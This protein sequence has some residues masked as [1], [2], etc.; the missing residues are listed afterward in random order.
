MAD[1]GTM[2]L[3]LALALAVYAGVG[4]VA[5][6][7]L[8]SG[9]LVMSARRSAYMAG[10]ALAVAVGALVYAFVTHDFSIE[11]VRGHSDLAQSQAYT[12]VAMYAGNEGSL[13]Y[14]TA[15]FTVMSM[16]AIYVTPR[17]LEPS[18]PYIVR[19]CPFR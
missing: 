14:I 16:V 18:R 4:S 5:G 19:S 13:L 17:R 3:L 2:S 9:D 11:Y 6:V 7:K 12:W 15:I 8:G 10:L 1:L